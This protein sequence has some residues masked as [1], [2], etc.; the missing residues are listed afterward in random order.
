[1]GGAVSHGRKVRFFGPGTIAELFSP[2]DLPRANG[3]ILMTTFLAIIFGTVLAGGLKKVL[4]GEDG[5]V[6]NLWLGLL[7]CVG[8]AV[9]GTITSLFVQVPAAQ[10]D[11][12]FTAD[13]YQR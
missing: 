13:W 2:R 5:S 3:I 12:K 6:Q 7:V 9:L 11:I 8:I 10:P 4:T 1:M